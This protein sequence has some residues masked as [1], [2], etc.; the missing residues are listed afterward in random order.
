MTEL[1]SGFK[2]EGTESEPVE[3]L[4]ELVDPELLAPELDEPLEVP[5]EKFDC[6]AVE[7][8][9]D[10]QAETVNRYE[11][12]SSRIVTRALVPSVS[13]FPNSR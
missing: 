12:P 2:F 8:P 1:F 13:T 7:Q 6:D 5:Y 10:L 11:P 4:F 3:P 9:E